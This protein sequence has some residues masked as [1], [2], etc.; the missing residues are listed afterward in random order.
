MYLEAKE[1]SENAKAK[2]ES[3][4]KDMFQFYANLLS[5]DTK[6]TWN[7]IVQEQTQSDTYSDLQGVS[8][9]EPRGPL[10]KSFD[11]CIMFHLLTVF[12]SNAAE[13]ERYNLTKLLKKPQHISVHQFVQHVEHLNSYI[14]QLPCWYYSPSVKPNTTLAYV[15]FTEAD[16]TSHVYWMCPIKWQDQFNL[17][18]K[19]MT[20]VDMHLLLQSPEAIEHIC[21]QEKSNAQSGEKASNKD[22]KGNKQPGTDATIRVHKKAC[23]EKH[24]NLCKKQG[25]MHTM[26]N[27]RDCHKYEKDRLK[28]AN[29]RTA[30]R[31][32]K[33]PNTTRQSFAQFSGNWTSLR[34]QSRN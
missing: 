4:V 23:T 9:K 22:K 5:V 26:H 8:K 33:K 32:G 34:R 20:P 10:C 24:C 13:Q 12:P 3:A 7:K 11:D 31:A 27:M 21:M 16:L 29:Y 15:P 30:K 17:H 6:Y 28:K 2:A 25:G 14:V 1:E 19:G 18:K